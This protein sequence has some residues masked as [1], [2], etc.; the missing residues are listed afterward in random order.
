MEHRLV[1]RLEGCRQH[2]HFLFVRLRHAFDDLAEDHVRPRQT[3]LLCGCGH[4]AQKQCGK[5]ETA[6]GQFVHPPT[7]LL[8][9]PGHSVCSMMRWWMLPCN[10]DTSRG[11]S[12]PKNDTP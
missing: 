3:T 9:L 6:C 11:R 1:A 7:S 5:R 2:M 4:E 8:H 12:D 10:P